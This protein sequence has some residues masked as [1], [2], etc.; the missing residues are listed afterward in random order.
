[1]SEDFDELRL[2]QLEDAPAVDGFV[3]YAW[4]HFFEHSV[5]MQ[6]T[7]NRPEIAAVF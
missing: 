5:Y 7:V 2:G 6:L 3:N 4:D 1:M